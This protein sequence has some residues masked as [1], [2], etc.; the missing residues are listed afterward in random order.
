LRSDANRARRVRDAKRPPSGRGSRRSPEQLTTV[1]SIQETTP[2][3]ALDDQ[4]R[5]EQA[6]ALFKLM[7]ARHGPGEAESDES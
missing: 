2:G 3:T 1:V 6:A 4:L 7:A 5:R